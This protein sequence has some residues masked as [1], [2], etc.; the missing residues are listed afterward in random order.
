MR[1][2]LGRVKPQG[3]SRGTLGLDPR[4]LGPAVGVDP[5]EN[6]ALQSLRQSVVGFRL[7]GS[8]ERSERPAPQIL[9]EFLVVVQDLGLAGAHSGR[10]DQGAATLSE[11]TVAPEKHG[12]RYFARSCLK[13]SLWV[14]SGTVVGQNL[15]SFG[16]PI[17]N[18]INLKGETTC[19]P[20]S[21]Q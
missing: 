17:L 11:L 6:H 2:G 9:R 13:T 5:E 12:M 14:V 15:G 20:P 16:R 19:D 3:A 10:R 8:L 21:S 1:P 7:D 18:F 4:L